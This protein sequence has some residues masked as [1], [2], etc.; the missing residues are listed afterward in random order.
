MDKVLLVDND[1][2]N[3]DKIVKGFKGLHHFKL[4]TASTGKTALDLLNDNKVSVFATSI[5]LPDINGVQLIAFM[6]RNFSSTPCIIML[7]PGQSK[8]W[9][10][11]RGGH[12]DFLYYLEKPFEFGRLASIIFLGLN[13]KDE[14]EAIKGMTLKHFLP[15]IALSNKTCQMEVA[16]GGQKIGFLYFNK[17]VL[18]DAKHD[19]VTGDQA[20]RDM[21]IWDGVSITLTKLSK[22]NMKNPIRTKLIDIAGATWKKKPKTKAPLTR[23]SLPTPPKDTG[24]SKLQNS[25]SRHM[26]VLR[27]IKGY[28]GLA[29]L[30]PEGHILAV[31]TMDESIDFTTFTAEFNNI[32]AE[33]GRAVNHT[34]MDRC[35][36]LTVHTPKGIIL[37]ITPDVYKYGNFRFIGLMSPEGNGYFMQIQLEKII[38]KILGAP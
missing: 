38:P 14:V 8:P 4:L 26:N 15:L 32:F 35:T 11:D 17:G 24:Q 33:C 2:E 10:T 37:I 28:H 6:T 36:G 31:D 9:F 18:L 22:K 16:S 1:K 21:A 13:L 19:N 5:N 30:N 12:E 23:R 34:G 25:L 7:D 20:A 27:T 3:L 29:V